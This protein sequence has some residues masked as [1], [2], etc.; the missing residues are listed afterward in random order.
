MA[1]SGW[2][3]SW[4]SEEAISPMVVSRAAVCRRSCCRRSR[5][6]ARFSSVTSMIELIQP[7]WRPSASR[8]GAS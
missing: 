2:F 4:A 3:S 5:S 1:P 7:V 6:S 8:S